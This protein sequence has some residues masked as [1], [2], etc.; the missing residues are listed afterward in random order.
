MRVDLYTM[1]KDV[2]PENILHGIMEG[3]QLQNLLTSQQA[4]NGDDIGSDTEYEDF[5]FDESIFT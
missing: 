4:M 2:Y 5:L 3:L 1:L